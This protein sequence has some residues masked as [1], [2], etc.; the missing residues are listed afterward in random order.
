MIFFYK[1]FKGKIILV[2]A[3]RRENFGEGIL[4]ICAAI[5]EIA[6]RRKD[7]LIVWPV[8]PN[9]N[10]R[11]IIFKKLSGVPNVKLVDPI[12][13]SDFIRLMKNSY[14]V[15]TDSGGIQEEVSFLG[16]PALVMRKSTER[17]EGISAGNIRLV[18]TDKREITEN[19]FR[20]LDDRKF[21]ELMT[22]K[23]DIFGDGKT[24]GRILGILAK[25]I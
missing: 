12:G 17:R 15:L 9:P 20:L 23:S 21:Y 22:K 14:F 2:T 5:K 7:V 18:G 13:Y 3:H 11:E 25:I 1:D 6:E 16:K 24:A 8:H 4:S 10:V 19:V